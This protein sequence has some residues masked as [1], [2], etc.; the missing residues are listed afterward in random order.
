VTWDLSCKDWEQRL[1]EGRSLV[2]DLPLIDRAAGDRAVAIF[3]KLRLADVPGTPTMATAAGD[4]FRDIVRALFG[5]WDPVAQERMIVELFLLIPKKNSKTTSA[6][7][8]MLTALLLNLRPRA[9]FALMAPVQDTADEAFAAAEGAIALDPVLDK[10]FHVVSHRKTIIHRETKAD[11]Q[12]VTFDPDMLTGKKFAG[13]LIDEVHVVAKNVKAAKAIRQVR[14]GMLPFPEAFLAFITTQSDDAPVGVFKAEIAKARAI[15]D[16]RATGKTLAVLYEFPR[17]MQQDK[18]APWRDPAN[19]SMVNPNLGRSVPLQRLIELYQDAQLKGEEEVRGWASQHLNIEIGLALL[20]DGWPGAAFWEDAAIE[21]VFG[22]PELLQRCEVATIGVDGG[23]L[24]DLL[25]LA[26]IGRERGTGRWLSWCRAWAHEIVLQRRKEIAEHLQDI[27]K[28]GDLVLVKTPGED[29][30]QLADIVE[31]VNGSGLLDRANDDGDNLEPA[32]GLDP[33]G[34]AAILTELEARKI[35]RKRMIG[36]QQGWKMTGA[37]K[38]LE[39]L[40]AA[41]ELQHADQALMDFAVGNAKVEP[42]G[43]PS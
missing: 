19:W 16:G 24:D 22:L 1:R 15:R 13:A 17:A 43:T 32:I 10:I 35:P 23:G 21:G 38:M 37:V 6:A 42:R 14:G 28:T 29:I 36:I 41:G 33:V 7:L 2:P 26:V 8:L 20:A 11:L 18:A 9:P 5:S 25:G 39:R 3:N 4:W 40:T 27:A 31:Q 12:I 34:I 30:T